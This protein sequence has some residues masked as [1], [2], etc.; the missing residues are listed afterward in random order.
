[1][2]TDSISLP[3]RFL[4]RV[5]PDVATPAAPKAQAAADADVF[6]G[7]KQAVS[8]EKKAKTKFKDGD[9][10]KLSG[11]IL[12]REAMMGIGGEVPPAGAFLVLDKPI[13]L[14]GK[15]VTELHLQGG[16]FK[17]GMKLVLN[18]QLKERSWGGV[19][20]KGGKYAELSGLSNVSKGEPTYD[21]KVFK[22]EQGE[23]LQVLSY[24][25]PLIMDAPAQIFVLDQA[26]GKAFLGS[27]GGFI[28]PWVNPFHGFSGTAKIKT[29]T[30][31]DRAE[32][33]FKNGQPVDAKTGNALTLVG[34][35]GQPAGT[36]DGMTTSWYMDADTN[37]LYSFQTGG[38]AGF[39]NR[40][41]QVIKL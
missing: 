13:T 5:L 11:E 33:V 7:Q 1:M 37:K 34:Q 6:V 40:M 30:D 24:N 22:N 14:N 10:T 20:T 38:I 21:G 2:L 29:A 31:K 4:N 15:K 26:K 8:A 19:E 9:W 27:R 16:D 25:R 3:L 39:V 41:A 23:K 18:G 36:A 17:K 28:P 35:S 32:V 12:I